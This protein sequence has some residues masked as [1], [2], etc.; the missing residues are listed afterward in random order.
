MEK[1][2]EM[3]RQIKEELQVPVV[4]D[5]HETYQA[6]PVAKVADILQIPAF[7]CRQTDL[8]HAAAQTGRVVNVK[9]GQLIPWMF[10]VVDVEQ[11]GRSN[12]VFICDKPSMHHKALTFMEL[13]SRLLDAKVNN[14]DVVTAECEGCPVGD[15]VAVNVRTR[16]IPG[17]QHVVVIKCVGSRA[18]NELRDEGW[19]GTGSHVVEV[20]VRTEHLPEMAR[21]MGDCNYTDTF[22]GEVISI[23]KVKKL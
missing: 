16:R 7:L 8:L 3:L 22:R 15:I 10:P 11:R 1:G 14:N 12:I 19:L 20:I 21:T 18:F 6:E 13:K 2:I 5:I 17:G 9:K 4:T 23:R